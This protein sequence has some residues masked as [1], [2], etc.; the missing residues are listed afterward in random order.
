MVSLSLRGLY[1]PPMQE[2]L[3]P[4]KYILSYNRV[5]GIL[6]TFTSLHAPLHAHAIMLVLEQHIWKGKG[7]YRCIKIHFD[8]CGVLSTYL[9][10]M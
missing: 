5:C 8:F 4:K 10:L 7:N 3:S 2:Y 6:E 9:T 1:I